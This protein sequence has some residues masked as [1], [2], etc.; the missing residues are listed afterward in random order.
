MVSAHNGIVGSSI[1]RRQ[2]PARKFTQ[3][4]PAACMLPSASS[5]RPNDAEAGDGEELVRGLWANARLV[6][7]RGPRLLDEP[8]V[9]LDERLDSSEPEASVRIPASGR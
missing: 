9:G 8:E 5:T 1:P 6:L 7:G 3:V 4:V 2:Q